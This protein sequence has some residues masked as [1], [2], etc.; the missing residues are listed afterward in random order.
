MPL[1]VL[2]FKDLAH[3]SRFQLWTDALTFRQMAKEA[4]NNYLR[5]M[6]V[7]N[8]VLS[9]WTTLE[10]ACCDAIGIEK[11]GNDFR[12]SLDEE[13]DKKAMAPLDFG[14]GIWNQINSSIKGYRKL[15]THFG[16]SITDRFP[17]VSVAEE[18]IK[19]IREAIYDIYGR[20]GKTAPVWV[21]FD[22]SSFQQSTGIGPSIGLGPNATVL[23][24]GVDKNDP[25]SYR[26]SLVT[27]TGDE[28]ESIWLSANTPVDDVM[29]EVE[30]QLESLNV[31]FKGIRVYQG[32]NPIYREDF[33]MRG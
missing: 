8:A 31:P 1:P 21:D 27:L 9:A 2:R 17:P 11:L 13:F 10:M 19:T 25:N 32:T 16:V 28:K 3:Q 14:S 30:K 33:D 6:S 18:A 23:R 12:R 24:G 15:Y 20:M 26:I 29:D 4:S 22:S 7:R 5:S